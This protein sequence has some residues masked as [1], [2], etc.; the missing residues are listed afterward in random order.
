MIFNGEV[1]SITR[2]EAAR[3]CG[4]DASVFSDK[5]PALSIQDA[6]RA[7]GRLALAHLATL[8]NNW[9]TDA[10]GEELESVLSA[11]EAFRLILESSN[12][13]TRQ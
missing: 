7:L 12:K 13:A 3:L 8:R 9:R 4:V 5:V 2:D 6:E 10:G 1:M 11:P